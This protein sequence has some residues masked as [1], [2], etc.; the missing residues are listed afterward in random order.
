MHA[1]FPSLLHVPTDRPTIVY[2]RV[3]FSAI[4]GG[5]AVTVK[6]TIFALRFGRKQF[7]EYKPR[8]EPVLADVVLLS[9]IATLAEQADKVNETTIDEEDDYEPASSWDPSWDLMSAAKVKQ[10]LNEFLWSPG[11]DRQHSHTSNASNAEEVEGTP[12]YDESSIAEKPDDKA[13]ASEPAS[14][15]MPRLLRR[16]D[17]GRLKIKDMLDAWEVPDDK[18]DKVSLATICMVLA[19]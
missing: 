17:S 12:S 6:G 1:F 11:I 3:L 19:Y 9:E 14:A 15:R 8:L 7:A 16:S 5:V 2:T 13:T 10:N 4:L 18:T